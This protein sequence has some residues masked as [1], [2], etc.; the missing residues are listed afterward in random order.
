[1]RYKKVFLVGYGAGWLDKFIKSFTIPAMA[2]SFSATDRKVLSGLTVFLL[3]GVIWNVCQK[4][5]RP[6]S[7][8]FALS[9][10]EVPPSFFS[11]TRS[12]STEVKPVPEW[13]LNLNRAGREELEE[14]PG[15]GP[16]LAERIFDYREKAGGFKKAEELLKVPGIGPKK[17]ALMKP[18]VWIGPL[19]GK[20]KTAGLLKNDSLKNP[21]ASEKI[22]RISPSG[23]EQKPK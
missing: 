17:F 15:V 19:E 13:P 21:A 12:A 18:K 4:G 11:S 9:V 22:V 10:I 1:M 3:A 8:A 6:I 14:L 7:P 16:A 20:K 2:S 5:S 23:K